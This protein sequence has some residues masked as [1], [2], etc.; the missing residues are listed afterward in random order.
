MLFAIEKILAALDSNHKFHLV[1]RDNLVLSALKEDHRHRQ[2]IEVID[3]RAID[4]SLMFQAAV[5]Y[6]RKRE[7][8]IGAK[9]PAAA[10]WL[11]Q[12]V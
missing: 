9:L 4:I 2:P 6:I 1:G 3:R 10:A 11:D 8:R 12:S 7:S 5:F